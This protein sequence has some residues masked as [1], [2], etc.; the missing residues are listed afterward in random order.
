MNLLDP[1]D[2]RSIPNSR[3]QGGISVRRQIRSQIS[4]WETLCTLRSSCNGVQVH[5]Y[6]V[7][8]ATPSATSAACLICSKAIFICKVAKYT[9]S[10]VPTEPISSIWLAPAEGNILRTSLACFAAPF[11]WEVVT[12]Q[13]Q[14]GRRH[15]ASNQDW[16][17]SSQDLQADVGSCFLD[18]YQDICSQAD[19]PFATEAL[20][21]DGCIS[22]L[23]D[24]DGIEQH[25]DDV[26]RRV[27]SCNFL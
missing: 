16:R 26:E 8:D 23:R 1:A 18:L 4:I 24:F 2:V 20:C 7:S 14:R 15:L 10:E 12:I 13:L 19:W 22:T 6:D 17:S 3:V 27:G 11:H 25:Q 5:V 9:G 21:H